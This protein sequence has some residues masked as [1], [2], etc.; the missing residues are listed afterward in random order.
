MRSLTRVLAAAS[1][2]T[3]RYVGIAICAVLTAAAGMITP[4]ILADATDKVVAAVASKQVDLAPF[5]WLAF[6]LLVAEMTA[7]VISNVGGYLGDTT[8]QR[9]R[10]TMSGRYFEKL[11]S[12]PQRYFDSQLTGTLIGRLNRSITEVTQFLQMFAN[13]F[14]PMLL[15]LMAVVAVSGWYAWPL[16]ILLILIYPVYTVLTAVTSGRW[17]SYEKSKNAEI[18]EAAGRFAEAIGQVRVVKAFVQE[19]RELAFFTKRFGT[20]VEITAAQSKWWHTMDVARRGGLNLI[21]FGVYAVIFIWTA[22]GRF[23]VGTMVLLLQLVAMAKLPVANMS[24]LVDTAQRAIAGSRDYFE[25]LDEPAEAESLPAGR[26]QTS[27]L[28]LVA[29]SPAVAFEDVVFSYEEGV[30]VLDGVTFDVRRGERVAFVGE[31]GGGKTTIVSLLLKLY[32]PTSGSV[33]L[34][35]H[36]V[37]STDLSAIRSHIGVVFQEASL[38]SGTVRENITY[39]APDASDE[40]VVEAATKAHAHP[41]IAALADGYETPIGERGVKLSG[42]QKQRIAIARAILADAPVLVLD[43][44]TS[45][46]DTRSE[47]AVQ[48]GLEELMADR[49]SL[50]VAHRLSTIASVDRIVTLKDGHVDEIGTPEE[51]ATSGGIYA[52]LLALQE[53][54]SKADRK[55]LRE[56]DIS[57]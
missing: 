57:V 38:F 34:C 49:T 12:L 11:L 14:L 48:A 4:F 17:Q 42:G 30:N 8:S 29:G 24:F 2:L 23:S 54:G 56:F 19:R 43:E 25:V 1:H 37:E 9:L 46:L 35:G 18:D 45:S 10:A 32:R 3:S 22:Q 28:T 31:S 40:E 44:A 39:G 26:L 20:S 15:T 51:L 52:Q 33:A 36:D 7:T 6:A 47:R 13:S 50:I 27:G 21:F 5:L 41:F 55:R 16:A 53:S